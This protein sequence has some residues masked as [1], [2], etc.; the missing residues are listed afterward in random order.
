[1]PAYD[2]ED[3]DFWLAG[4]DGHFKMCKKANGEPAF[5]DEEKLTLLRSVVPPEVMRLYKKQI[6]DKDYNGFKTAISG[7]VQ[8]TDAQIYEDVWAAK[9]QPHQTPSQYCHTLMVKLDM[10]QQKDLK[11]WIVK[12]SLERGLHANIRS[13]MADDN[14]GPE[15]LRKVDKVHANQRTS[16]TAAT[17]ASVESVIASMTAAGLSETE[18]AF[19]K[20]TG[21]GGGTKGGR[22]NS[23]GRS[24]ATSDNKPATSRRRCK[25]HQKFGEQA[26]TCSGGDCP[27]KGKTK[28]KPQVAATGEA[29]RDD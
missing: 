11:K 28:K 23:G 16:Q 20:K 25:H 8:K 3:I 1:M 12:H 17:T 9:I 7:A 2:P 19:V 29:D 14:Y 10:V 22:Y 27:D 6:L 21:G 4:V 15:Y 24:K 13:A 5:D 26:W 18:V